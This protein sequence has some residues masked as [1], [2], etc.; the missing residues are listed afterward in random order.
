MRPSYPDDAAR[1]AY[2][3]D[4]MEQGYAFVEKLIAFPVEECGEPFASVTEAAADA[5]V[6]MLFSTSK[7]AG[8]LDRLYV[9]RESLV[10]DVIAIARDMNARGWVLKIEDCFRT[11]E[12][13]RRLGRTPAVFTKIFETCRWE[14]G[15]AVP[16]PELVF[17]RAIV[18]T[19]N[20][21]KIGAHMSGSA[22]DISVF[23]RDDGRE[24]W[25]GFPYV[26]VSE[27]T[28]M[29]SPF[30]APEF[31]ENR[32]AITAMME[33]RGFMHFPFEFWHYNKGDIGA[34]ILNGRTEPARFGAV[35]WDPK[36]NQVTT[37][38]DPHSFLNPLSVVANE[39]AAAIERAQNQ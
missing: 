31:I 20:M 13:Q 1:R 35:D 3:T 28:P 9:L 37:V 23:Q 12:M 38:A 32:L 25:R 27:H 19:A 34:Q 24:V 36:T 29:R 7:I 11:V 14:N 2:W 30:V 33:A 16:S 18:M 17:R 22:I 10:E 39:I 15:G 5:G 21:P 4:Q 6:E 26:E 8:D